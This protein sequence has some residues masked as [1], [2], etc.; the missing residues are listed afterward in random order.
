MF[1]EFQKTFWKLDKGEASRSWEI[2]RETTFR[3]VKIECALRV[4]TLEELLKIEECRL[5]VYYALSL[6]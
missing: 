2:E 3:R 5:L 4:I 1:H 6:L